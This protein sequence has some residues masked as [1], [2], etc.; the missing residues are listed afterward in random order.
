MRFDNCQSINQRRNDSALSDANRKPSISVNQ[1]QILIKMYECDLFMGYHKVIP[2][3]RRTDRDLVIEKLACILCN[4]V[5][6]TIMSC[7]VQHTVSI[8]FRFYCS[9]RRYTLRY[10]TMYC[11]IQ[12]SCKSAN[13]IYPFLFLVNSVL[14]ALPI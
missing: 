11:T 7:F 9:F 2:T 4:I 1:T 14:D 3:C 13:L 8:F 5:A 6:A 12:L 10:G